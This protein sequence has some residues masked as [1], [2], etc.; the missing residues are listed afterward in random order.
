MQRS[1]VMI[2]A[3]LVTISQNRATVLFL[4]LSLPV[5]VNAGLRS[6]TLILNVNSP[7]LLFRE[8]VSIIFV[9]VKLAGWL[10]GLD[11]KVKAFYLSN[12]TLFSHS[13]CNRC[14]DS[15]R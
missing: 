4:S 10:A 9:H 11:H 2:V 14:S 5:L 7:Q 1:L 12:L 15:T 8:P 3:Y 13:P 6:K